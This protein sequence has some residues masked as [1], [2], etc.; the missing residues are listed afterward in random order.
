MNGTPQIL[1]LLPRGSSGFISRN[2]YQWLS[3]AHW[4]SDGP[5]SPRATHHCC[6]THHLVGG[7]EKP[8]SSS[9]T[10][11]VWD[12]SHFLHKRGSFP[13][14]C[15]GLGSFTPKMN[16]QTGYKIP[17]FLYVDICHSATAPAPPP[18][19]SHPLQ[20]G[21][22][23]NHRLLQLFIHQTSVLR[24]HLRRLRLLNSASKH[25]SWLF[26]P[27]C[28]GSKANPEANHFQFKILMCPSTHFFFLFQCNKTSRPITP[29]L[30]WHL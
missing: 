18:V 25:P 9:L 4:G 27:L 22:T 2:L 15:Q 16:N 11:A 20:K 12:N 14:L 6:W 17:R 24:P 5:R 19:L 13:C 29:L 30:R 8:W 7:F 23:D 28:V 10:V 21:S 1:Q 3:G 26:C